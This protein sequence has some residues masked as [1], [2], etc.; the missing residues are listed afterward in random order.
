MILKPTYTRLEPNMP[1]WKLADIIPY[2]QRE[3]EIDGAR[4]DKGH[5]PAQELIEMIISKAREIDQDFVFVAEEL[6]PSNAR[7]VRNWVMTIIGNGFW[8]E[9]R[10]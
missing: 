4:I 3:F 8:M 1:L 10:I 9:S 6:D 7:K 2:Y 5:A